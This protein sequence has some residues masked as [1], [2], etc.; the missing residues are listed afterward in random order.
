MVDATEWIWMDGKFVKWADAKIHILTH[1]LHY[2]TGVFEGI[3]FYKTSK[4]P[5]VFRL[6]EHIARLFYSA[7]AVQMSMPFTEKQ[8]S[9][10]VCELL[11][12]NKVTCGYIRPIAYFGYG[13]MG[14]NPK[15]SVVNCSII[16]WPWGAYLSSEPLRVRLS[17]Y[18]RMH[19]KTTVPDAKICGNYVN[20]TFASVEA[21]N[22]GYHEALLL[23]HKGNI[24]EGP[25]ENIFLVKGNKLYTPTKGNILPGIT[26]DSIITIAKDEGMDVVEKTLTIKD[27]EHA[28]EAFFTG[29]AAEVV[30]I[31]TFEDKP[32]GNG[33]F[34]PITTK[35]RTIYLDAV[36]G[37]IKKYEPWLTH[38]K[39]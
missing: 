37:R 34:G 16:C 25:G 5:A 19:P 1:T 27:L 11:R 36:N 6:K 2:G 10:A 28:D 35:L 12:K 23:D 9:D 8:I 39:K 22:K 21:K 30:G 4:G 14:L 33:S 15:D 7:S 13:V 3:R 38:I 31:G 24:A 20:S 26:R 17:P 18:M 32:I 29:T